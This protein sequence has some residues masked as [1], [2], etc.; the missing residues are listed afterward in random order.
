MAEY[1]NG[2]MVNRYTVFAKHGGMIGYYGLRDNL[3]GEK[4]VGVH[5]FGREAMQQIAD[6]WNRRE[7]KG[8]GNG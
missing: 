1:R 7:L 8:L 3:K 6:I 2:K 5:L 4:L